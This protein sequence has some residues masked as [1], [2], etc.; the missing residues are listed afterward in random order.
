LNVAVSVG[1]EKVVGV[2]EAVNAQTPPTATAEGK[3]P[4]R[5]QSVEAA[6]DKLKSVESV[7]PTEVS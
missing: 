4:V 3:V 5:V 6:A 7:W 1:P 2:N